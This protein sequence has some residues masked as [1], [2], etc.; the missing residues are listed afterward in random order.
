MSGGFDGA[1]YRTKLP[2]KRGDF[3]TTTLVYDRLVLE[4]NDNANPNAFPGA[5]DPATQINFDLDLYLFN[6]T[7]GQYSIVGESSNAGGNIEHLHIPVP[8]DGYY[9]IQVN[10]LNQNSGF[11][12]LAWWT[13]PEPTS[14]LWV[15]AASMLIARRR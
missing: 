8:Y 15:L 5:I 6:P 4:N 3:F 9:A 11:Y 1:Y 14:M 2:L 10:N 7:T 12:G 13:V